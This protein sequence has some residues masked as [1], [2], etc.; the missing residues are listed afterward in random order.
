MSCSA[1]GVTSDG[2]QFCVGCGA[3]LAP[4]ALAPASSTSLAVREAPGPPRNAWLALQEIRL[5]A[6]P[7]CGA[8]N[9]AARWHCARC[10]ADFDEQTADELPP[11]TP[12]EAPA[13]DAAAVQPEAAPW[14]TLITVVAGVAVV[15]VA[16][17]ML[18]SR[19]VGPFEGRAEPTAVAR[20]APIGIAAASASSSVDATSDARSLIDGDTSTAWRT[21]ATGPTWIELELA[22]PARVDHLLVWNGDQASDASFAATN[23]VTQALILFPDLDK[24]YRAPFEDIDENF[25]IDIPGAPT[26][27]RIRIKIVGTGGGHDVTALSEIEALVNTAPVAE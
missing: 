14:L 11:A 5:L 3:R 8:P 10:G 20:A 24:A 19:G 26:A 7:R 2:G 22:E 25:R 12:V 18:V 6:C 4:A 27:D 23:R 15:A 16:A 17:V 1:C 13:E 21:D 9:S